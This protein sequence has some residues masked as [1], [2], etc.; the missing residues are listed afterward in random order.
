VEE[1]GMGFMYAP[2]YHPSMKA[3]APVRKALKVR[4]AF[5]LLGPMLNPAKSKYALVGVY[6]PDLQHLMADSL[7]K[8]GMKKALVVCSTVG[9]L[10]LDEMTPCGPTQVV[11]VTP[12]GTKAYSFNPRD[13]G[14]PPCELSDLAGGDAKLNA[15]ILMDA[16]GGEKGPVADCLML[17]AGVA[18][19]AVR[20]RFPEMS[21]AVVFFG[22]FF[23]FPN[24]SRCTGQHMS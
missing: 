15:Q 11:E 9:K 3:V 23:K 17:N 20:G 10:S 7:M 2:R 13:V 12:A 16:L 14:I 21:F 5:N 22:G 24:V 6:T 1:V 18:M 19:A 4:T 8:L